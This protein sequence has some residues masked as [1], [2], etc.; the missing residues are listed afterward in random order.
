[1]RRCHFCDRQILPDDDKYPS[2]VCPPCADA[3]R[4][5]ING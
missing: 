2:P 3:I 1:M 5:V 4:D